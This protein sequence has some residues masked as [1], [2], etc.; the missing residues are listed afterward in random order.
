MRL[1]LNRGCRRTA[2]A[3]L[4]FLLAALT[5]SC[6]DLD[7]TDT[8]SGEVVT[9]TSAETT[10]APPVSDATTT[11]VAVMPTDTV[12]PPAT[13]LGPPP[14]IPASTTLPPAVTVTTAALSSAEELLPSGHI[15]AMG[16]I[17]D[18]W[19]SGGVRHLRIDYAE[20]LTGEEARLAAIAAGDLGPGETL[21][22]DYYISNVNP[23]LREFV[24]SNSA[25]I[26]TTFRNHLVDLDGTPCTWADFLGFWG[27]G[28][29]PDGDSHLPSAPWW[30]ERD[31]N[32]IVW[33]FEQ[34]IP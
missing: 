33:I 29:L 12:P 14:T 20:M 30:I 10:T 27:P 31:G 2:A 19:V 34:F 21:D 3:A 32:T 17:T 8:T 1:S 5:V 28:P 26:L 16:F 7:G 25:T 4:V 9:V 18:V 22:T 24:V 13:T 15:K 23:L 11:T 6:T